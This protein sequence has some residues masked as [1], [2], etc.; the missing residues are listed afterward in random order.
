[1][2]LMEP[3]ILVLDS[4][5]LPCEGPSSLGLGVCVTQ[6]ILQVCLPHV[7]LTGIF[8][9]PEAVQQVLVDGEQVAK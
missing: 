3:R 4:V 2:Q 7:A 8:R 9:C 5:L 1:M 6:A